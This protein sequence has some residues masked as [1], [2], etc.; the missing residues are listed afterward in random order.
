MSEHFFRILTIRISLLLVLALSLISSPML[1]E[2]LAFATPTARGILGI[3]SMAFLILGS[4]KIEKTDLL[5]LFFVFLNFIIVFF[6]KSKINNVLSYLSIILIYFLLFRVLKA[7]ELYRKIFFKMWIQ[8]GYFVSIT[9]IILFILNQF[10]PVERDFFHI[11]SLF[12]L[13]PNNFKFH[14]LGITLDKIYGPFTLTRV[15]GYF[16][17]PQYIGFFFTMN[18]LLASYSGRF[19]YKRVWVMLNLLAGAVTFSTT[20]FLAL[21]P[22]SVIAFTNLPF[23]VLFYSIIL[24]IVFIFTIEY[25]S[26]RNAQILDFTSF[27]DREVRIKSAVKVLSNATD[28]NLFFGHGVGFQNLYGGPAFSAGFFIALIERGILGLTFLFIL[29][30]S[31]LRKKIDAFIIFLLYLF[32]APL[33]VNYLFWICLLAIWVADKRN[34]EMKLNRKKILV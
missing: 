7:N 15:Y 11:E 19:A 22:I 31:S 30:F 12:S 27:A 8:I 21:I 34:E 6:W 32:A 23:R 24:L 10:F 13:S 2:T 18:L 5:I 1:F 3:L 4:S 17:E 25:E 9:A 29:M 33:Y 28:E 26:I 14:L 20:F 16:I